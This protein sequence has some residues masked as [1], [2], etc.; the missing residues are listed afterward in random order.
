[1]VLGVGKGG[2]DQGKGNR[3]HPQEWASGEGNRP[4]IHST[5]LESIWFWEEDLSGL[6]EAY[7][8]FFKFTK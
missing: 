1:M 4:L 8:N 6:P 2:Q 7:K 5:Y 3:S